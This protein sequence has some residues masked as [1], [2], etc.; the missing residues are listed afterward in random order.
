MQSKQYS[1]VIT[2]DN[3]AGNYE[4]ELS[5]WLMG[6]YHEHCDAELDRPSYD[7]WAAENPEHAAA[8]EDVIDC[9]PYDEYGICPCGL[10]PH[11]TNALEIYLDRYMVEDQDQYAEFI[12]AIKA[13]VGPDL[14]YP[15]EV[16]DYS[17]YPEKKTK[18]APIK[19]LKI[20]LRT[21]TTIESNEL[22]AQV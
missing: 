3:Y 12:T 9:R 8:L 1:L 10:D 14:I 5:T 7:K 13:R 22:I 21:L 15:R 16:T 6:V 20:E 17:A 11:N 4:R 19:I 18:V 2:T